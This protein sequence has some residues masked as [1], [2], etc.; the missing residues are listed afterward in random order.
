MK[1]TA[2][3][4]ESI[5]KYLLSWGL[6]YKDFYDE[7]L[8]HFLSDIER[9]LGDGCSFEDAWAQS[10][11]VF[12]NKKFKGT[13]GLKAFETEY[14]H[15][16]ESELK[17]KLR[18]KVKEQF[19]SWR[20]VLWAAIGLNFIYFIGKDNVASFIPLMLLI[21]VG[22]VLPIVFVPF[23][24]GFGLQ[25]RWTLM[26]KPISERKEVSLFH[27]TRIRVLLSNSVYFMV[28][29]GVVANLI[30]NVSKGLQFNMESLMPITFGLILMV[31]FACIAW[32]QAELVFD[33][34]KK[35]KA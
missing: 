1:L 28:F 18:F 25:T 35:E 8:D 21:F 4:I 10:K 9:Q 24:K 6:E 11:E 20:V 3:Q 30:Y 7:V 17:K 16:I 31:G 33:E 27:K 5:E 34:L 13:Y 23:K 12:D 26:D 19:T 14:I 2:A 29:P 22:L 32:A 15:N